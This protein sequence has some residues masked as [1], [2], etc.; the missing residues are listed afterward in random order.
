MKECQNLIEARQSE[1]GFNDLKWGNSIQQMTDQ[2]PL[3]CTRKSYNFQLE[4]LHRN[5]YVE[6]PNASSSVRLNLTFYLYI[7]LESL[8]VEERVEALVY[9]EVNFVAAAGGNLGLFLGFSCFS[10]L[11]AL[12]KQ[13]RKLILK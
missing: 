7:S 4:Y 9:D 12:I 10:V 11:L 8:T 5:Q 1:Q 3:P 6:S 13:V 2:C